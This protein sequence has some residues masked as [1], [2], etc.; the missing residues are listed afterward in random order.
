MICGINGALFERFE[1]NEFSITLALTLFK[2]LNG[3]CNPGGT[4][5]NG[6]AQIS[7]RIKVP[8]IILIFV[9]NFAPNF[10]RFF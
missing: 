2:F 4:R 1:M 3:E 9:P 8:Q 6:L 10:H 7:C 5:G